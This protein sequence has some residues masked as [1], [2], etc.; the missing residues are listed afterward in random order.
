MTTHS[1]NSAAQKSAATPELSVGE[2]LP[3]HSVVAF[4]Y[5]H[6][7]DN[8]IHDDSVAKTLGFGGGLVPG[9]ADYAYMTQPVVARL[10]HEWLE[11]GWADVRFKSPVY[12]DDTVRAHARVVGTDPLELALELH[13]SSGAACAVGTGGI[14][15]AGML[16]TPPLDLQAYPKAALPP[17]DE[18]PAATLEF[19]HAGAVMGSLAIEPLDRV[20]RE[21]LLDKYRDPLEL[22]RADDAPVHPAFIP[23]AA[24]SLLTSN[25]ELG[26]WIHTGS[27]VQHLR[28][29][30][31]LTA[32]EI[33]GTVAASYERK[34]HD[35]VE[36][37][38]ALFAD[39]GVAIAKVLHTAIIRVARR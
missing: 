7:S 9:V 19:L 21:A 20:D 32:M 24:N 6:D 10:G 36:L 14:T 22:Y 25:A 16:N 38:L 12:E 2:S 8:K 28:S 15:Q 3:D 29:V 4:N 26:P 30:P 31:E 17:Y 35:I 1:P 5:A 11:T 37:D 27:R 33:R 39:D 18:R 34:G 13:D 23:D